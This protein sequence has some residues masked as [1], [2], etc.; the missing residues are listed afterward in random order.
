M[1]ARRPPAA[2]TLQRTL[3]RQAKQ[4]ADLKSKVKAMASTEQQLRAAL[5][6]FEGVD[7]QNAVTD[8]GTLSADQIAYRAVVHRIHEVT[9]AL[10][11]ED[12]TVIVL[13]KAERELLDLQGRN[14]WRF[15]QSP[16]GEYAGYYPA[17]STAAIVHLEAIRSKGAGFLLIPEI[18]RWWLEHYVDFAQHVRRR[19]PCLLDETG[20]G[21]YFS[22]RPK[23]A[24]AQDTD[25]WKTVDDVLERVRN[26][27]IAEPAILDWNTGLDL[28]TK[29]PQQ[30]VFSPPPNEA[31]L[32]YLDNSIDIVAVPSGDAEAVREAE[33]VAQSAV[34][35]FADL[36]SSGR[37]GPSVKVRW[38]AVL[39]RTAPPTVSIVIP[40]FNGIAHTDACLT[41]LGETLPDDFAGEIV[42]VDDGSSAAAV[43]RLKAWTKIEPRLRVLRNRTNIGFL[44]SVNRGAEAATGDILV[45]LNND[46]IPIAGWLPPLLRTFREH[47]NAGAVGGRLVYPSGRLQEAGGVVFRDGSAANF[48]RDDHNPD[49]PLYRVFREVDYCSAALLATPRSTFLELGGFD[50]LYEPGYYED[51]DYCFRLRDKGYRV[52][53]Q[54]ESV[55]VH[56]EGGTA[57]LDV[58][59]GMK[60]YQIVNQDKFRARWQHALER[61]A[62]RPDRLDFV[63]L[64]ALAGR[65]VV[66]GGGAA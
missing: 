56:C 39:E 41:A 28:V 29:L 6:Q 59:S 24:R 54:P 37:T 5:A 63:E 27:G 30:A 21:L 60:R 19:Y 18:S 48:G 62:V 26:R 36:E 3:K 46:T 66:S 2:T 12:A 49:L 47:A 23:K 53:L 65:Y 20:V 31:T 43:A 1:P 40:C 42:V 34:L 11:P 64:H 44:R 25:P 15:P 7:R 10:V 61:Q 33:R 38:H 16:D 32:P 14:V 57:G 9:Q 22:L 17:C 13:G 35:M 8:G 51:T 50:V 58:S 45:F 4:L 52:F 55:V